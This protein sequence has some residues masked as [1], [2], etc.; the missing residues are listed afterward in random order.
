MSLPAADPRRQRQQ[1]Q[2][3]AEYFDARAP[4]RMHALD[5]SYIERHFS[6]VV[7]AASLRPGEAVCEWGAGMGRFSR[8]LANHGAQLT[9]IELSPVRAGD[10]ARALGPYPQARV[11]TGDIIDVLERDPQTYDA[12]LGFFVLHHLPDLPR[13]LLAARRALRDNGRIVFAEPNPFNPLYPVQI[14]LT[15]GM[16]WAAERGIYR[17]WPRQVER[18]AR[19]AG[20]S[21][22]TVTRYGALP[23]LLYNAAATLGCERWPEYVTP[24][25]LKA[26]QMIV[27]HA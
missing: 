17:L 3:Q 1:I 21:R 2:S 8:L 4:V 9:A 14:T 13:Y 6:E 27:A 26:F 18:A 5:T 12:M 25:R 11:E 19:A 20:F 16:R 10:C 24:D 15:P 22:V 23:R 7:S